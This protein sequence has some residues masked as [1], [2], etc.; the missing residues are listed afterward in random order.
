LKLRRP[1][2]V[3]RSGGSGKRSYFWNQ[4]VEG[5]A[6]IYIVVGFGNVLEFLNFEIY[7]LY[8]NNSRKF[9]KSYLNHEKSQKLEKI[10]KRF[11]KVDMNMMDQKKEFGT[12]E[13]I[14]EM[15]MEKD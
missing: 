13:N 3:D 2:C 8:K 11:P 4:R 12:Q 10:L 5:Y 15:I 9:M 14:I 1:I 7:F 6:G